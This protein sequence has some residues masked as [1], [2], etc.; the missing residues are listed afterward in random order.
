MENLRWLKYRRISRT[1]E[2][3]WD[4]Q[5]LPSETYLKE[6]NY[7]TFEEYVEEEIIPCLRNEYSLVSTSYHVEWEIVDS[8]NPVEARM[9]ASEE[10]KDLDK[11]LDI[12]KRSKEIIDFHVERIHYIEKMAQDLPSGF[13]VGFEPTGFI[14]DENSGFGYYRDAVWIK[15]KNNFWKI[16]REQSNSEK[17]KLS[18]AGS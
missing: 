1:S 15:D 7:K 3:D 13:P 16:N 8:L 6:N 5:E 17:T 10:K 14:K 11:H 18:K 9:L 4:Y 12:I 2:L